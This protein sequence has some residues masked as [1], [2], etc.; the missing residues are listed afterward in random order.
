MNPTK[1]NPQTILKR[2]TKSRKGIKIITH[3]RPDVDALGSV[4][5]MSWVLNSMRVPFSVCVESWLSFSTELRPLVSASEVDVQLMLDVSDPKRAFGY[6]KGLETLVIDHHAVEDVPFMH[7]I[8]PSCC[9]TSAL[10]S[11]LF[12]D[13]LDSKSSV[14][15]LAGLLADTGVLSYSNVDERALNDA[16]RLVQAG[17]NW[18]A[19]YVEAT[20][21]CGMEQAKRIARLLRKVYEYK[22]GVFVLSVPKED[23]LEQGFTDDDFSIA[24]SIMQWIGRGVLFI[25]ARENNNQTPVTNISF[26]SRHPL[27]A[28]EYAKRLNGGGHRMAAAAKVSNRLSEVMETVL[29][30]VTADVD[31]LSQT[32]S[33]PAN[34]NELDL[35]LAELYAKSELLSVDVTEELLLSICDL[36]SKGASAERAAMKVRENIDLESLQQLSDWIM[37]SDDLKSPKSLVQ[38]MFYRQVDFS[39]KS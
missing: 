30:W 12:S 17:A 18:N 11:E 14:C 6:D 27:E 24:L 8:D 9:A 38:R 15:F 22:P 10:L 26:R 39:C 1:T 29:A 4:A 25:S 35:Q 23:R 20:K 37:S 3:E 36:V 34:L 16:I 2:L 13:H 33:E 21:I 31:A 28:I 5:G 7:L 19:A 32:R